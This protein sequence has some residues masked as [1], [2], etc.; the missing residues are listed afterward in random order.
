MKAEGQLTRGR[1]DRKTS[2]FSCVLAK[3]DDGVSVLLYICERE[4]K[5][6]FSLSMERGGGNMNGYSG[7]LRF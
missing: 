6:F 2:F 5:R 3:D 4:R 7:R 1:E